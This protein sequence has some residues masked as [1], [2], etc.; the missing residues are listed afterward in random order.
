MRPISDYKD[1]PDDA[2]L[3]AK[4]MLSK[5]RNAK[6]GLLALFVFVSS[7]Y[8]AQAFEITG[9]N[10]TKLSA[11]VL[12]KFGSPWAMTIL[13]DN[14]MLVS[15][16]EGYLHK[17]SPDGKD[18]QEVRNLPKTDVG[19]QGGMGDIVLHPRFNENQLVYIS[20]VE[21]G[22]SNTRGAV[23]AR[24]VLEDN[25]GV[26]LLENLEVIW[27]Q[28]PKVTG[29]GHYSHRI[30][31]APDGK[32]F[33]SSGDRQKLDPAQDMNSALGKLIRLND[34][35]TPAENNPFQFDGEL[36]KTFWS[37]GHRNM[38]GIAFDAEG[39][40]WQHEMGPRHGDELNLSVKGANYGWPVVSNG[41]HYSG[42]KIPN[43]DTRLD[44]EAPKAYWV[45][46]IAPSGLVIYSG[47][48]FVDWKGGAL[49]G[50]LASQA[51]IHVSIDGETATE[52]ERFEWGSRVREVE[53]AKDGAIYVLE[54]GGRLLRL[55]PTN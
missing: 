16:R 7:C 52:T 11:E 47:D 34:D 35:G 48:L 50:G 43:H 12:A 40:L 55:S 38:L 24:G 25:L 20:Y 8:L 27:R 44:F 49:I 39:R 9:T 45:P 32:L 28:A 51:L 4:T 17:V 19:G 22:P 42:Q 29:R 23:V 26:P 15:E 5:F 54:D 3:E 30:A 37:L 46:T 13:P 18:I 21:A 31:F 41:N 1:D 2:L 14:S 33:I 6:I 53:Q 10:G 36:A